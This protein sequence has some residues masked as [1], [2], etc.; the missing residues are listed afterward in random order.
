MVRPS[1]PTIAGSKPISSRQVNGPAG[2]IFTGPPIIGDVWQRVAIR[3][4]E[5]AKQTVGAPS[6]LRIDDTGALFRLTDRSAQPLQDLLA[7]LLYNVRL[8]LTDAPHVRGVIL[9]SGV[10]VDLGDVRERTTWANLAPT[11]LIAPG[12]PRQVLA[13][14]PAAMIRRLPGGRT[15]MTFVL[16]GTSTELALPAGV[17]LEPGLWYHTEPSWLARALQFLGYAPI[18]RLLV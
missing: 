3:I 2:P 6:W 18:E 1:E 5:K 10:T 9:T 8:A 16:P 17:S 14:G 15:R 11:M 4:A 13:E 7:D 12:P